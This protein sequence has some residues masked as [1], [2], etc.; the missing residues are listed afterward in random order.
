MT[1]R[2]LLTCFIINYD[3]KEELNIFFSFPNEA[4]PVTRR[5]NLRIILCSK[6]KIFK[7][8]ETREKV[9]CSY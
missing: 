2:P 6:P 7:N 4:T 3:I 5:S 1:S 9:R 8:I